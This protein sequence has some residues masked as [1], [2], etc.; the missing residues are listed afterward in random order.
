MVAHL[1]IIASIWFAA[2]LFSLPAR[3]R[4][5]TSTRTQAATRISYFRSLVSFAC[6]SSRPSRVAGVRARARRLIMTRLRWRIAAR[7][8]CIAFAINAD[9]R[10]VP[11]RRA[12]SSMVARARRTFIVCVR[13]DDAHPIAR[14]WRLSIC[15][16]VCCG[17][18]F[19]FTW[20]AGGDILVAVA[21]STLER[22][23]DARVARQRAVPPSR[24]FSC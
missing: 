21:F 19:A 7:A 3:A 20:R 6:L 22:F 4:A 2:D 9:I 5:T 8:R 14:C 1:G 16:A 13:D 11:Q 17:F 15:T 10:N 24:A 18:L 12:R 23:D